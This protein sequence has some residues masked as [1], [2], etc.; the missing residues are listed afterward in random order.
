MK[1]FPHQ[2]VEPKILKYKQKKIQKVLFLL[3][4]I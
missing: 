3:G 2:S 1:P 4:D